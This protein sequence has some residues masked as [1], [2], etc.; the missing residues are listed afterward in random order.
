MGRTSIAIGAAVFAA[1]VGIDAG[2]E[3]DVGAV[4]A[5]DDGARGIFQELS[6]RERRILICYVVGIRLVMKALKAI[7]R[8]M[9][10]AAAVDRFWLAR[11]DAPSVHGLRGSAWALRN[12]ASA[13]SA[14]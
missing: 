3:A 4:V 13:R 5:G 12:R 10:S 14:S 2:A 6:L 11:H 8:I 9:R 1:A 7:G